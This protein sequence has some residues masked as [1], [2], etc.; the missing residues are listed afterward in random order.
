MERGRLWPGVR[1]GH[2]ARS[3]KLIAAHAGWKP[4]LQTCAI[5]FDP[6]KHNKNN[7]LSP[8]S[9]ALEALQKPSS[10]PVVWLLGEAS[11]RPA[12]LPELF[13]ID[14]T[15]M[16]ALFFLRGKIFR[17]VN[18]RKIQ[19]NKGLRKGITSTNRRLL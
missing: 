2:P 5:F 11:R 4:A 13:P 15:K 3:S 18:S 9:R 16:P 8:P 17:P 19:R 12:R 1:P 10:N 14:A 6:E 7:G